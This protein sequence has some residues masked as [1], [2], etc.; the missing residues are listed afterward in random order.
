MAGV[1]N[2][3]IIIIMMMMMQTL[4]YKAHN[5]ITIEAESAAESVRNLWKKECWQRSNAIDNV[6]CVVAHCSQSDDTVGSNSVS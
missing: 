5:V 6:S 3:T 1:D 4:I 2:E